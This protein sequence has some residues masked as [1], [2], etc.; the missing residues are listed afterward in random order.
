MKTSCNMFP[1]F[2]RT[3]PLIFMTLRANTC[4]VLKRKLPSVIR[5]PLTASALQSN[6]DTLPFLT[7]I[8]MALFLSARNRNSL[9]AQSSEWN[10]GLFSVA[11]LKERKT[12]NTHRISKWYSPNHK[13]YIYYLVSFPINNKQVLSIFS[14]LHIIQ[15]HGY[16]KNNYLIG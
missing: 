6:A 2:V 11:R 14:Q 8:K 12:I 10:A 13:N 4:R 7:D 3:R 15:R 16:R 1:S 5:F 9:S